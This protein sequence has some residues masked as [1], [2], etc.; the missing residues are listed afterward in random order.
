MAELLFLAD[1]AVT[2]HFMV[3]QESSITITD[4]SKGFE[5]K[6][7]LRGLSLALHPGTVFGLVGLNGAGKT[8]LIRILL[9]LLRADS[10][11]CSVLG[12]DPAKQE[13]KLYKQIGVILE[14]NGFFGNLTARENLAFFAEARGVSPAAVREYFEQYWADTA[15][16]TD[17]RSVKYLS[18]GQKMQC[19]L[20]RA[21]LGWPALYLFDEPAVALDLEAYEQFCKLVHTA[22]KQGATIIISSHQLDTIED[23]CTAVGVLKNGNIAII[24]TDNDAR[25]GEQWLFRT[26]NHV[27]YQSIIAGESGVQPAYADGAW[28]VVFADNPEKKIAAIITRLVSAGAAISEVRREK[29]EYRTT[30]KRHY[31]AL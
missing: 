24:D 25:A 11:A 20:C 8:T 12:H 5:K 28:H 13:K 21:F 16:G 27:L 18:R 14:H 1:R 31:G 10:G 15:L 2:S 30:I 22:R 23:L 26:D 29:E 19:A 7:V 9:G 6:E 17:N 4:L 3:M